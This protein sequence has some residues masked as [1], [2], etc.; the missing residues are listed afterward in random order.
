MRLT[1]EL[2]DNESLKTKLRDRARAAGFDTVEEFAS[3]IIEDAADPG[4]PPH[5]SFKDDEELEEFLSKRIAASDVG[6]MTQA[7]FD[8]IRARLGNLKEHEN[9]DPTAL[10]RAASRLKFRQA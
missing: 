10:Q 7:D 8:S 1:I 2:P 6:E 9:A 3:A 5:L 4:A